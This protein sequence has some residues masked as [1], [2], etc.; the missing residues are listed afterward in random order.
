MLSAYW[1]SFYIVDYSKIDLH[2][3]QVTLGLVPQIYILNYN[4]I[5]TP[6]NTV[7]SICMCE[8]RLNIKIEFARKCVSVLG[9]NYLVYSFHATDKALRH[10][11]RQCLMRVVCFCCQA[12]GGLFRDSTPV[13]V[14]HR[15]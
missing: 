2:K 11:C 5:Q 1:T 15:I 10:V 7:S 13:V 6:G 9:T 12:A 3:G 4:A 8:R 14:L